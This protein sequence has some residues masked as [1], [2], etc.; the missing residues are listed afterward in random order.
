MNNSLQ[1]KL[2]EYRRCQWQNYNNGRTER[3]TKN[4]TRNGK[5]PGK[6]TL[7][8]KLYK[9]AIDSFHEKLLFFL[10]TLLRWEKSRKN[11]KTVLWYLYTRKVTKKCGK[12]WW[13]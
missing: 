6:D 9:Y 8:S 1:K 10:I 4:K 12:L 11:G 13:N 3:S 5:S 7:N 2:L